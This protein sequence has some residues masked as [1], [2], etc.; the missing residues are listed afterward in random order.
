MGIFHDRRGLRWAA[1]GLP[2]LVF[3]AGGCAERVTTYQVPGAAIA[4]GQKILI[5]PFMD[6]RTFIDSDD[7]HR[8]NLGTHAR[9]IFAEAVR[10][11]ADVREIE[12]ATPELPAQTRSLANAEVAEIGRE[13]GAQ[14]VVAGQIFSFTDTR[15]VSIPPR[16]G[17]FIRVVSA[18]DGALLFVGDHYQSANIPGASGGRE[19]QARNVS[20]RLAGGIL[21]QA[22]LLAAVTAKVASDAALASL[23]ASP[24]SDRRSAGN[25]DDE[26]LEPPPL[27]GLGGIGFVEP[28]QWD[29]QI[30]PAVPPIIDFNYDLYEKPL[31]FLM[32]EAVQDETESGE[33][34]AKAGKSESGTAAAPGEAG[35]IAASEP[36]LPDIADLDIEHTDHARG[37]ETGVIAPGT[38]LENDVAAGRSE[39]YEGASVKIEA[40]EDILSRGAETTE[41][42]AEF[43]YRVEAE[44][45]D[46]SYAAGLSGDELMADLFES[47][48]ELPENL[49]E[50]KPEAPEF[51]MHREDN[52]AIDGE[53]AQESQVAAAVSGAL[54]SPAAW[55]ETADTN[56]A[57]WEVVDFVAETL[58]RPTLVEQAAKV[59]GIEVLTAP[60]VVTPGESAEPSQLVAGPTPFQL[61]NLERVAERMIFHDNGPVVSIPLAVEQPRPIRF[62]DRV[63]FPVDPGVASVSFE[64]ESASPVLAAKDPIRVL[65]LPYH[66]RENP[67]NLIPHTGG[68]EVVTALYG[69]RLALDQEVRILWDVSGQVTHDRLVDREE[70]LQLGRMVDADFVIRGQVVEFRRAQSV[71]SFYSV[72]ISTAVLA[73]QMFFAEMT[74]VDVATEVYRVSDGRC[75]MSR[76]DRAQQK[77]VVQAE[78]TVRRLAAGMTDGVARAIKADDPESMEP[79]IDTLGPLTIFTNPR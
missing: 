16:A 48:G 74:G 1:F 5:L 28:S 63:E 25:E 33:E 68:G 56:T 44:V 13:H 57:E 62:V 7:P 34:A 42:F 60:A 36:G 64:P 17:M 51:A 73:A 41:S 37:G 53:L 21:N 52:P 31:P 27:I 26:A 19:L 49:A 69:A 70:A 32:T 24:A 11:N 79:L 22:K 71:P 20:N 40:E 77:Y 6:T 10:A 55:S 50:P 2:V 9:D 78:K 75:V 12:I 23:A 59:Y 29:D 65:I 61:E 14:V 8:N 72:V 18:K 76:R 3:L 30:A 46:A 54:Q 43:Y 58:A 15:A 4:S 66:D 47:N 35:E 39:F 45:P 38:P 67:N